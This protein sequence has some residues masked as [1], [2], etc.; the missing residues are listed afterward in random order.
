MIKAVTIP[1]VSGTWDIWIGLNGSRPCISYVRTETTTSLSFDLNEF[2][3]DAVANRPNTIL[4]SW[5]LTNVFTGFEIWQGGLNLE[6]TSFCA[7]VN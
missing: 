6:T 5:Y 1:D 4:S 2:I 3:K 7:I